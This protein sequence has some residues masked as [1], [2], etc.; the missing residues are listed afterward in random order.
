MEWDDVRPKPV[1]GAAIGD[2][3]ETLS[4]AEL[5]ARIGAL[6]R[7]ITRVKAE[8]EAKRRHENAASALFKR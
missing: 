4:V 2:N 6:E 7:E 1:A 5:E 8:L 3:L